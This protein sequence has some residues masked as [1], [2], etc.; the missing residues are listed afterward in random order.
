[1]RRVSIFTLF[2]TYFRY[3]IEK[4]THFLIIFDICSELHKWILQEW[5]DWEQSSNDGS[6][7]FPKNGIVCMIILM[8]MSVT[9]VGTFEYFTFNLL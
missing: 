7:I 2:L 8:V 1:M 5:I 6:V 9:F 4:S 3:T